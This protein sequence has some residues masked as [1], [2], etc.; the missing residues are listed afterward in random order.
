M[1]IDV[2]FFDGITRTERCGTTPDKRGADEN[3]KQGPGAKVRRKFQRFDCSG[4]CRSAKDGFRLPEY[5]DISH[6]GLVL[7]KG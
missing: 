2:L 3:E 4:D 7:L 5:I 6:F 1:H